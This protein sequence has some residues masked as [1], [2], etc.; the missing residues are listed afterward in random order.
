VL[1]LLVFLLESV[2]CAAR[3]AFMVELK[4]VA[5]EHLR[6][7]ANGA[8]FASTTTAQLV[9]P[10]LGALAL[11][12][13][14]AGMVFVL[15]GVTFLGV[16]A[17]V[18]QV[19]GGPRGAASTAVDAG[20]SHHQPAAPVQPATSGY[21]WLLRRQDLGLYA[22]GC[23]S[24]SL[25]TQAAIALF[26]VRANTL[27]LGDGGVGVFFAAVA[28][29]S[30]AGSIIAGGRAAHASP[31]YPAAIAMGCCAL[32]L[33]TFG[34]AGTVALALAALVAV[35]FTTDFYEVV[36]I[37][38][39]QHS[40]PDDAYG[41]FFSL[42]LIA[43][44]AGGLVGALAGPAL[45]RVFGV[46]PSLA[47]LAAPGMTLALLLAFLSRNWGEMEPARVAGE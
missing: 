28:V 5:P 30:I 44:S 33:A 4:A 1:F 6:A 46:A 3:P 12:P 40:I 14:G 35:G 29:G 13:F 21:A 25:L 18:A 16:A 26:V 9:G 27:G 2:N 19:R 10:L 15:N 36:G 37:T 47:A 11:A 31:L 39:F 42:F 24:L 20:T 41:R 45:E 8:L 32:A 34:V 7:A 23:L 43:L 38:Y 17:A 22:L